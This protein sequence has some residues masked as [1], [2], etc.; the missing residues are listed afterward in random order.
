LLQ[1]SRGNGSNKLRVPGKTSEKL[2]NH[3][4][5]F[6]PRLEKNEC[7]GT[8]NTMKEPREFVADLESRIALPEGCGDRFAGYAIIGLPFQSGHVLAA[9]QRVLDRYGI[10]IRPET[11]RFTRM[12]R[13]TIRA[14]AISA[15]AFAKVLFAGLRWSGPARIRCA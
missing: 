6:L 10:G 8:K 11:G 1:P 9:I 5:T 13:P 12:Y 3:H 4:R 15:T 14:P 2:K 7:G